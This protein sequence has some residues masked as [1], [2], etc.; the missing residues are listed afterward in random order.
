MMPAIR[1]RF[2]M[3]LVVCG[4][5]A[6]GGCVVD[7]ERTDALREERE[8]A[9]PTLP[10]DPIAR[11]VIS[12]TTASRVS[13]SIESMGTLAYDGLTVPLVSPDGRFAATQDHPSP[14]RAARL[15]LAEGQGS[16]SS[17]HATVSVSPL[18]PGVGGVRPS[19]EFFDLEAP[20]VLGRDADVEGVLVESP[21]P[22]GS[23]WIG[24]AQWSESGGGIRWLVRDGT[25]SAHA[26]LAEGGAMLYSRR[27]KAGS[28]FTLVHRTSDGNQRTLAMPDADLVFPLVAPDRRHVTCLAVSDSGAIDLLLIDLSTATGADLG[29]VV[30]RWDLASS[31]G[32]V[33]ASQIVA[34][35]QSSVRG[36]SQADAVS[37]VAATPTQ[38]SLGPIIFHPSMDRCAAVDA[39]RRTLVALAP[40]SVAAVDAGDGRA[41]CSTPNGLVLWTPGPQA[42]R[43]TATRVLSED[44][45]PRRTASMERPFVLFAPMR[46]SA[47]DLMVFGMAPASAQ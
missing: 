30:R 22:D 2:I 19:I 28:R 47:T 8:S 40:K 43:G 26:V 27:S 25:V 10:Q 46:R 45:L 12:G 24:L 32:I 39:S 7:D 9:P 16:E 31:G 37:D 23:R 44:Y 14:S 5:L 36:V 33:G 20:V 1:D 41:I 17:Q 6:L 42:G 15:A 4:V 11:P 18:T 35:S 29:R 21:R 3:G 34:A 38:A 13:V